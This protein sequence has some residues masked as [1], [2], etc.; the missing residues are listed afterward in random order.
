[1]SSLESNLCENK[2][3]IVAI[4]KPHC[5]LF[6]VYFAVTC[7]D[8]DGIEN[9]PGQNKNKL[10][11]SRMQTSKTKPASI[12]NLTLWSIYHDVYTCS[13]W[14]MYITKPHL[15][16]ITTISGLAECSKLNILKGK[17]VFHHSVYICLLDFQFRWMQHFTLQT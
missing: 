14:C 13:S 4:M 12:T 17:F 16:Y 6:G 8:E 5:H 2:V 7:W 3:R 10:Y 11:F 9:I 15:I 1:M